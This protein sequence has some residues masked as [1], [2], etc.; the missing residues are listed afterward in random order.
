MFCRRSLAASI[1]GFALAVLAAALALDM[2]AD[3][4]RAAL[5]VFIPLGI[6]AIVAVGAWRWLTRPRGW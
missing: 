1:V 4:L 3:L 2:A 6:A 5:P